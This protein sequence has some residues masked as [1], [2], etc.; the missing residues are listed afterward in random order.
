MK[1][2]YKNP[3]HQGTQSVTNINYTHKKQ[4]YIIFYYI[5]LYVHNRIFIPIFYIVLISIC[6]CGQMAISLKKFIEYHKDAKVANEQTPKRKGW[7]ESQP[8][9]HDH[10]MNNQRWNHHLCS[11]YGTMTIILLISFTLL[12]KYILEWWI[13]KYFNLNKDETVQL[14]EIFDQL[15]YSICI[16]IAIYAKNDKLY[17]HVKNEI[18]DIIW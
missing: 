17:K 6:I 4:Y 7:T 1:Q 5:I 8:N 14:T 9:Q 13:L 2:L 12:S 3:S 10:Q 18:S 15:V 11:N 16:P